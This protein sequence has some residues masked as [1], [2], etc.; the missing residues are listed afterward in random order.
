MSPGA[1]TVSVTVSRVREN[2]AGHG[3]GAGT[4]RRA[5]AISGAPRGSGAGGPVD[6]GQRQRHGAS[7]GMQIFSQT[8]QLARPRERRRG[9]PGREVGGR[10]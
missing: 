8:S 2:D 5:A 1:A 4:A 7:S 10:A 3:L 6:D 9:E